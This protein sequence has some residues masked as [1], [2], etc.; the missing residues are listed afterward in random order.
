M[1]RVLMLTGD[2]NLVKRRCDKHGTPLAI[3]GN[4][5]VVWRRS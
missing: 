5:L 3:S 4:E 2:V 1:K